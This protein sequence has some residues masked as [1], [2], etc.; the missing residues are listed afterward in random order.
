MRPR[1]ADE[2]TRAT[3]ADRAA[4][5]AQCR[6]A[7][8]PTRARKVNVQVPLSRA[9]VGSGLSR[10]FLLLIAA[11]VLSAAVASAADITWAVDGVE[12]SAIIYVP[13][14]PPPG[15]LPLILS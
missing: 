2:G 3:A 5:P 4:C 10:T 7:C 6:G 14:S 13:K 8:R 11:L 15:K 9:S 1:R 12:R